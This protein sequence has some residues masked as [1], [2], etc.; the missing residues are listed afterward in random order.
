MLTHDSIGA[1]LA[2]LVL[3]GCSEATVRAYGAD[4]RMLLIWQGTIDYPDWHSQEVATATYLNEYRPEW[5]PKT[6]Q[7]KLTTFRS[8]A[9]FM[10]QDSFLKNYRPPKAAA[11]QP[12]PIPEG[13]EGVRR[14]I[15]SAYGANHEALCTLNGLMGLRVEE[16]VTI[17]PEHFDLDNMMLRFRGK[18]DK[19]REVPIS[20]EAWGHLGKAY[21]QAQKNGTTLVRLTN[22]GA[23]KSISR[24]GRRADLSQH[25]ASHDL[26]A[27]AITAA[28]DN[29]KDLRAAQEIAGHADPKTTA[30][31]TKVSH[32]AMRKA[33]EFA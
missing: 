13:I 19:M 12:H 8:W 33:L 17:K 16:C 5:A 1:F 3:D 31:Y 24:H 4:L 20:D 32:A 22:R 2:Q 14:M 6:T 21:R 9:R 26:R 11:Q 25:V 29:G 28:Y 23:R 30:I 27:T 15:A 18:G 10:G 7:R